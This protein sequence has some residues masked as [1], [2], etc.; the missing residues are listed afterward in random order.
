MSLLGTQVYANPATPCWL[1]SAGGAISGN[2]S[3]NQVFARKYNAVDVAGV[4][5][6]ELT[7]NGAATGSVLTGD[8]NITFA[9]TGVLTGN[10]VLTLSTAGANLDSLALGG[11]IAATGAIGGAS[12][13]ATGAVSGASVSATSNVGG[14]TLSA[15]GAVSA[16]ALKIL[17]TSGGT[18]DTAGQAQFTGNNFVVNTTAVASNSLI[19]LSSLG[20][21]GP[22]GTAGVFPILS[23]DTITPGTSF[24]VHALDAATGVVVAN[25]VNGLKF[26]WMIVNPS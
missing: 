1:S 5:H 6:G 3:A 18:A 10:T 21:D 24:N 11:A 7:L 15:T 22:Y 17:P 12:L 9:K 25:D 20:P 13:A 4:T 26:A 14:A 16:T 23:V 19:Y 2:I 8:S